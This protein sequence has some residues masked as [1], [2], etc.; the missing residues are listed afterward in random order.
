M[1]IDVKAHGGGALGDDVEVEAHALL[2][3]D[4]PPEVGEAPADVGPQPDLLEELGVHV[5]GLDEA[6]LD[7]LL[8]LLLL[9]AQKG[10][11]LLNRTRHVY[12]R[13]R[14]GLT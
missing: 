13:L 14:G 2:V 11:P 12:R 8:P 3:E 9:R 5:K 1:V 10:E 4:L 7:G 6:A